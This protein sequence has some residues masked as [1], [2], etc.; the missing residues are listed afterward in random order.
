MLADTVSCDV[1]LREHCDR[2]L[3]L[4]CKCRGESRRPEAAD[5][6][7]E[8]GSPFVVQWHRMT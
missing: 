8:V 4:H 2:P 6:C 7:P 5:V 1:I 3:H